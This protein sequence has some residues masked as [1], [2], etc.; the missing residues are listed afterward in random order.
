MGSLGPHQSY[1][2]AISDVR[3]ASYR[4]NLSGRRRAITDVA[5]TS[6]AARLAATGRRVAVTRGCCVLVWR[7]SD[8]SPAEQSFVSGRISGEF[9][10]PDDGAVKHFE[11]R[12]SFGFRCVGLHEAR[13]REPSSPYDCGLAAR[14][15]TDEVAESFGCSG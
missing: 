3:R 14:D 10:P 8:A 2:V 6:C 5:L 15:F 11:S 1:T 9:L 4:T 13:T 7:S 12:L